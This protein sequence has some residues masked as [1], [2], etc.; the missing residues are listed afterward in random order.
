MPIGPTPEERLLEAVVATA[1]GVDY[2][3]EAATP[4]KTVRHFRSRHVLKVDRNAISYRYQGDEDYERE[5]QYR[6]AHERVKVIH[7]GVIIDLNLEDE[8][9]GEDPT[10]WGQHFR[11]YYAQLAALRDPDG[12]LLQ[13]CDWIVDGDGEPDEDSKPDEGRLVKTISVVYRV[14]SEAPHVLLA[15]GENG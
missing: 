4:I 6:N 14:R 9:G 12:P 8:E 13:L 1:M 3:V 7:I 10:G 15:Q 11:V 2:E 5:G